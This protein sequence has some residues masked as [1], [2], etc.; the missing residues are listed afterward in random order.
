MLVVTCPIS[1]NLNIK[2]RRHIVN[3]FFIILQS[4]VH[5]VLLPRFFQ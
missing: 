2:H 4:F 3:I 5:L 1:Y